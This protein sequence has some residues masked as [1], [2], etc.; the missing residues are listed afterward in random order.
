MMAA[1]ALI[2]SACGSKELK[3]WTKGGLETGKYRS[4]F[5]EM[6]YSQK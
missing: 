2:L 1:A 3:P 6:G 4:V 5:A